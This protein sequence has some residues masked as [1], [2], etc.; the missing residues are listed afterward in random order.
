VLLGVLDTQQTGQVAALTH[1]LVDG[2]RNLLALIP[3]G[4]VWLDLGVDPF[5]DFLA[6]SGVR[7]V[8]V[9]GGILSENEAKH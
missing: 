3:L 5:A 4:N 8:E 1:L 6:K 7:I 9:R 2:V